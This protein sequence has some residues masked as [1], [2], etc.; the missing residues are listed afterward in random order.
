MLKIRLAIALPSTV[1][2]GILASQTLYLTSTHSGLAR[3]L[4]RNSR[5]IIN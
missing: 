5:Y 4:V 2:L 1:L 3:E